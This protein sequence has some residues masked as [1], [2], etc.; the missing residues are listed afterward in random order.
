MGFAW[1]LVLGREPTP[2][3]ITTL[4]TLLESELQKFR[5]QKEAAVKLATDP[6]GPLPAGLDPAEAAAWTVI[7]N[8]LLNLDG[9][10]MKS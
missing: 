10:L 9:M 4:S 3:Q 2:V 6:L 7:G 5:D 1:R 8:V